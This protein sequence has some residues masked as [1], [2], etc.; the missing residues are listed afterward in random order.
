MVLNVL[1]SGAGIAGPVLAFWLSRAGI[2]TTVI[3]RATSLPTGGQQIDVRGAALEVVRRMGLEDTVRSRTTKEQGLAFI[4]KTG[5]TRAS[6]GVDTT[7]GR[8]FTS[9][10]E[11][12]RGELAE[13]FFDETK[14]SSE[15]IFGDHITEMTQRRDGVEVNF[16][17]GSSRTF[18]LVVAADGMRSKTRKLA[19]GDQDY[20][21]HLGMYTCYFTIPGKEG[22][23]EWAKWYNA[24]GRRCILARPDMKGSLRTYLSVMSEVP[25]RYHEIGVDGQKKLMREI[26]SDA[27]WESSRILDGMDSSKDFYMQEIAQVKMDKWSTGRVVMLGDAGYCPSPISGVGTSLALIG[28]YVLAGEIARHK[29]DYQKGFEEYESKMQKRVNKAQDLPP[30][31]PAL[32]NP[33]SSWGISIML[34]VLS[35]ASK[36]GIASWFA[37][38]PPSDEKLEEYKFEQEEDLS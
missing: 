8:S 32:A 6:F 35:I 9:D 38:G 25:A 5:K 34:G 26:F 23:G 21:K 18:D 1:I 7:S 15:Y 36:T 12:L 22:D 10:I 19:F 17:K 24:P 4:D 20:L 3:E 16:A 13:I 11:I 2:R 28:A 27:G 33:S 37:G 31:A 29:Q 30:G 14:E